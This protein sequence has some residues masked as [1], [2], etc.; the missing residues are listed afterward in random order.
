[1]VSLSPSLKMKLLKGKIPYFE[2]NNYLFPSL[3]QGE[4]RTF[5]KKPL[6]LKSIFLITATS[7]YFSGTSFS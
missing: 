4:N 7:K 5:F 3:I 1:M 6:C 2:I